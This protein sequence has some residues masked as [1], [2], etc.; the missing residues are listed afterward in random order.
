LLVAG[1]LFVVDVGWFDADMWVLN[2]MLVAENVGG[3]A[4][5]ELEMVPM[6]CPFAPFA[7]DEIS[8]E[9]HT[10]PLDAFL[11][12]HSHPQDSPSPL[13]TISKLDWPFSSNSHIPS[14]LL[15]LPLALLLPT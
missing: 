5:I 12:F 11:D 7:A 15:A 2:L 1:H 6:V 8:T 4:P 10:H 3:A 13:S 9:L 14:L